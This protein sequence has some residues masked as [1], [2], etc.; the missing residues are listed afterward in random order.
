MAEIFTADQLTQAYGAPKG[1]TPIT[2][3][4][5]DV[6]KG[7]F[8]GGTDASKLKKAVTTIFSGEKIGEKIGSAYAKRKFERDYADLRDTDP[9]T[10]NMILDT[11]FEGPSNKQV[12]AD[13]AQIGLEFLPIGRIAKGLS[14]AAKAS[15][16]KKGADA[17]GN[18][19]AGLGVGYGFDVTQGI[20]EGEEDPYKAGVGTIVGATIPGAFES[21]SAIT[22]ALKTKGKEAAPR[23]INSLIKPLKKDFSF[24][25]DPGRGVAEEG[26]VAGDMEELASK[27]KERVSHYGKLIGQASRDATEMGVKI[28][29][30]DFT[31]PIDEAISKAMESPRSNRSIIERLMDIKADLL[32]ETSLADGSMLNLRK[33]EDMT[34]EEVFKLKSDVADLTRWTDNQSADTVVNRALRTAYGETQ[35]ALSKALEDAG[36]TGI[37]DVNDRY[38]DLVTA[39]KS[40]EYRDKILQRQNIISLGSKATGFMGA[41]TDLVASGGTAIGA[42]LKGVTLGALDQYMS[43]PGFKTRFAKAL[44]E[45]RQPTLEKLIEESPG[46]RSWLTR[47]LQESSST[48]GDVLADKVN[49]LVTESGKILK[50]EGSQRGSLELDPRKWIKKYPKKD[51]LLVEQIIEKEAKL[52]NE[53]DNLADDWIDNRIKELPDSKKAEIYKGEK[54]LTTKILSKLEGRTTVSKQFIEDLTNQGDLRQAERDLFRKLLKDET[55]TVNVKDFA[56]KVKKNLLKIDDDSF[57]GIYE[58]TSLPEEIRGNV[59]DYQERIYNSPIKTSA[60]GIHYGEDIENY[61]GHTRVEDMGDRGFTQK[62]YDKLRNVN[63]DKWPAKMIPNDKIRRVIE[64]QSD[65]FQKGRLDDE[66]ESALDYASNNYSGSRMPT[67]YMLDKMASKRIEELKKLEPYRNT[68]HERLIREEIKKAAQDGKTK[69]Q[70]PTG[71]T[72][73]KIEGLGENADSWVSRSMER[74]LTDPDGVKYSSMNKPLQEMKDDLFVGMEVRNR[75]GGSDWIITDVL[76]DGKFKAAPKRINTS[77]FDVKRTD[78]DHMADYTKLSKTDKEKVNKSHLVETFDI[79]GKIDTENPIYKFYEK[80]VQKF[81]SRYGGK[82]ITDDFGVTWIEVPIKKEMAKAPI[83]AFALTPVALGSKNRNNSDKDDE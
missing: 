43:A 27:I 20:K 25:K 53:T 55:N 62:D 26:I 76:G 16:L 41:M 52:L 29:L 32:K 66:F 54:D 8:R 37:R 81:L 57:W 79:S 19:G 47:T 42:I 23:I 44:G 71:E 69:L 6:Q 11:T 22:K 31:R 39:A 3:P 17:L 40:T 24:G 80:D 7:A 74:H 78:N 15:K 4:E 83:E 21:Y 14:T 34:P 72:A 30:P 38:A 70:F 51:P 63:P 49:D 61:F 59:A 48:P 65:L 75:N 9:K 35:E 56:K 1:I 18:I 73:M 10:Y 67:D 2:T 82:K 5:Q 33:L 58:R 36:F 77:L 28:S 13:V 45:M 64:I 12:A 68:W 60:G 46:V 50:K